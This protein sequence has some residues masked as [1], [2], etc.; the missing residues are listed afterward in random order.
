MMVYEIFRETK[1]YL[2]TTCQQSC[3]KVMSSLMYVCLSTRAGDYPFDHYQ[4]CH[5]P[6]TTGP[7]GPGPFQTLDITIQGPQRPAPMLVTSGNHPFRP[8]WTCS[9]EDPSVLTSGSYWSNASYWN[10]FLFWIKIWIKNRR[11]FILS[12]VVISQHI[13]HYVNS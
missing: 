12:G 7:P 4:W 1:W 2:I 9:L 13:K 3:E 11:M 6:H 8:V 5:G 10:A